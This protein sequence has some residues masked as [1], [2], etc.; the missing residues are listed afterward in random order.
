MAVEAASGKTDFCIVHVTGSYDPIVTAWRLANSGLF[1]DYVA[2]ERAGEYWFAG[3][4][5]GEV[6]V[7][8]AGVTARWGNS[9]RDETSSSPPFEL[10][11]RA[12]HSLPWFGCRAYGWI[13]FEMAERTTGMRHPAN[14]THVLLDLMIPHTEVNIHSNSCT[15]RSTSPAMAARVQQ[16]LT[17]PIALPSFNVRAVDVNLPW[18]EAAFREAVIASLEAIRQRRLQKVIVSRCVTVPFPVDFLATYVLGRSH[19]TPA[20]SFMLALH[21]RRAAGFAP[22]T[23]LEVD[24]EGWVTVQ[25]L[26]GTRA[27]GLGKDVDLSLRT[28]LKHDPKEI[29]E[30][31]ISVR[32]VC[33]D[34]VAV[35]A[36][37]TVRVE[38][39]MSV[40]ERGSAQH[41]ASTVR[42]QLALGKSGWDALQATFP[43]ITVSGIPRKA[44]CELIAELEPRRRGLYGGAVLMAD[45]DGAIDAA[46]VLRTIFEQDGAT[47]LR[48]GAGIVAGST[49]EREFRET[50][51]KL[52]SLATHVVP[53]WGDA[54]ASGWP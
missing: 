15:I 26:A 9:E 10:A 40:R 33:E 29:Y 3:G 50:C 20:R 18:D 31:S 25:P 27:C 4:I 44:A 19:N 52:G 32:A 49:P 7:D 13:A 8:A 42:G 11:A 48:A 35:C 43:A 54:E 46:L 23:V 2:Y 39:F 16:L 34:L 45:G 51:E 6:S 38:D 12:L 5:L 41:L 17:R 36:P 28:E 30:H 21:G 1:V 47:W 37:R 14:D 53:L 22:E 24:A